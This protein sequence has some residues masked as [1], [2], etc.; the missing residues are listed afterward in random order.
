M[1]TIFK[2]YLLKKQ[3]E[4]FEAMKT[5]ENISSRIPKGPLCGVNREL[6]KHRQQRQRKLHL[7]INI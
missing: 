5:S 4:G 2:A 7:K 3:L 1:I 6:N